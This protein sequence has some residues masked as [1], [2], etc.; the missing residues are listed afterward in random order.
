MLNCNNRS[1]QIVGLRP[2]MC[3]CTN[4]FACKHNAN[5]LRQSKTHTRLPNIYQYKVLIF[6]CLCPASG[7]EYPKYRAAPEFFRQ[8]K[9]KQEAHQ[10]VGPRETR[11]SMKKIVLSLICAKC[12]QPKVTRS[13]SNGWVRKNAAP[14]N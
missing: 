7:N 14:L 9:L 3:C 1:P 10:L 11:P 13:P 6:V 5:P 2:P 4:C 8:S 12:G